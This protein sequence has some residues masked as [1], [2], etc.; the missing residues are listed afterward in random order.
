MTILFL[1]HI[2]DRHY[3]KYF[4][5]QSPLVFTVSLSGNYF[6]NTPLKDEETGA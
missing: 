1:L 6:Y 3:D 5:T 4:Y 2:C